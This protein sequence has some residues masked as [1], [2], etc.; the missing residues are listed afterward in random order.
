MF[1]DVRAMGSQIRPRTRDYPVDGLSFSYK[2]G[3]IRVYRLG[4]ILDSRNKV[5]SSCRPIENGFQNLR[6]YHL[7]NLD[8]RV[9]AK[10]RTLNKIMSI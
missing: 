10:A 6:I 4:S 9:S 7:E 2:S 5:M 8:R 1:L 3:N